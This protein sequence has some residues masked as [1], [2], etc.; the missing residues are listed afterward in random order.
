MA[1]ADVQQPPAQEAA[2][3]LPDYL[4][5]PDAVLGD[6]DAKWRYGR[7]PD[8]SKTRKIFAETKQ[9]SHEAG[10]LPELVQNLVKNWE[11][12]ASFKPNLDD[13]RTVDHEN[14]SFAINGSEP[15]GAENSAQGGH[16]QRHHRAQ[17]ILR[18]H[19][20]RLRLVAQDVQT[21]DAHFR[22][23]S[24]RSLQRPANRRIPLAPLGRHEKR[25]RR[26]QQQGRESDGQAH[27]GLIDIEA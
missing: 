5:N 13:W 1:A 17:R 14:Y 16:I 6:K 26:H 21:H 15:Q 9:K 24:P 7:A 8:Y 25:L 2:P 20:L 10:S 11:V 12:E 3:A 27:G 18:P 22:L 4:T 19:L 23:G